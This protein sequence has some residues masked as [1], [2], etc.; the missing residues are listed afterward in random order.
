[1]FPAAV[2]SVGEVEAGLGVCISAG[3]G[4][5]EMQGE[6]PEVADGS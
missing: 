6:T 3:K 2:E 4:K 5:E 1:M